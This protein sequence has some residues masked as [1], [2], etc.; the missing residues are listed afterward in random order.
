[1]AQ[2]QSESALKNTG[3]VQTFDAATRYLDSNNNAALINP[4]RT[5]DLG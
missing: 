4:I 3:Q 5:S 2:G 1:M